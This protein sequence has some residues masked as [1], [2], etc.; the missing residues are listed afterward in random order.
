M[1]FVGFCIGEGEISEV[2][3][4]SPSSSADDSLSELRLDIGPSTGFGSFL[5]RPF[6]KGQITVFGKTL[7]GR[8]RKY[9]MILS[10]VTQPLSLQRS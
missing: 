6:N 8:T 3:W 4:A 5:G 10:R 2:Y 1:G 9:D 7:R